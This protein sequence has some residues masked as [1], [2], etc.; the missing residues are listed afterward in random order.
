MN[1]L[2][3]LIENIRMAVSFPETVLPDQ[4]QKYAHDYAEY[5]TELNR[6]I[7]QS[8]QHIRSGNLAE[9]IRLAEMKPNLTEMYQTLD[10]LE[11]EEW[12]DIVSTLG[13]EI[14][15]P[16]S[17]GQLRELNDAYLK[18]SPLEPL[19]RQHRLHALNGSPIRQRLEI[20]RAITKADPE[21]L[22]WNE[23]QEKFEQARIAELNKEIQ[24]AVASGNSDQ[25]RTLYNELSNNNWR[26]LPP[27]EFRQKLCVVML[28][29]DA[30]NLLRYFA[31]FDYTQ[32]SALYEQIQRFLA[33]NKMTLPPDIERTIRPAVLW[34]NETQKRY[35]FENEFMRCSV[36]L[37]QALETES[38]LPTLERLYYALSTAAS[39]AETVIPAELENLY[40]SQISDYEERKARAVKLTVASIVCA[41]LLISGLIAWGLVQRHRSSR[42]QEVLETLQKIETEKRFDD[43]AGTIQRLETDSPYL[44]GQ[45]EIVSIIERLRNLL[46]ED[47]ERAKDFERYY[48]QA[49]ANLDTPEKPDIY[50]LQQIKIDVD[51]AE[52]LAR[53]PQE[54]T[55]FSELKRKF[56]SLLS[57]Q[58]KIL[59]QAYNEKLAEIS[60][61]FNK[62]RKNNSLEI[63]DAFNKFRKNNSLPK[64]EILSQLQNF[65]QQMET[66]QKQNE[67]VSP[68]MKEQ[69]Q[70]VLDSIIL[71]QKKIENEIE[72]NNAF[73]NLIKT[74]P[75]WEDYKTALKNF[76]TKYPDHPAS[77]DAAEVLKEL[78]AVKE[79]IVPLNNLI[80][81]YSK[82][83]DDFNSLQKESEEMRERFELLSSKISGSAEALFSE[84]KILETL[85]KMK[86]F[87]SESF[88]AT[89]P[90]LKN[91]S[92]RQVY[93]W[94]DKEHWYYL[95][96]KPDN[97]GN[98]QYITT[99]VSEEKTFRIRDNEFSRDK[100][101]S[102]TQYQF[103]ITALKKIDAIQD[104]VTEVVC[105]LLEKILSANGIDPILKCVFL[106]SL[107][108]D[109]SEIDPIFAS[110]FKRYHEIVQ[111]SGVDISTNWMDVT[112][113]NTIPQRNLAK[114]ALERL[115]NIKGLTATTLKELSQF[116]N[117][118][119][120]FRP[121]FEW[122]G[123][124][125]RKDGIWNCPTKSTLTGETGDI[126]ILRQKADNTIQPIKIGSVAGGEIQIN[127]TN[128]YLQCSP[129]FFKQ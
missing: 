31:E 42:I 113:K 99:L 1:N 4:I 124:L 65:V 23:D 82:H 25:I 64:N 97:A 15:Q 56:D 77:T 27:R 59:D 74:V 9:G 28:R 19:L 108:S 96:Q 60:D 111:K 100:I 115:P 16:L 49:S 38:P 40:R 118:I 76:I 127:N 121:R 83:A 88:K 21:N 37:Q 120:T 66:L 122:I 89:E 69:G 33:T 12:I 50:K 51:Q 5:C 90:H 128:A 61:A 39:Q 86:P 70:T 54:K 35:A 48:T 24:H 116:K 103:S 45:V 106:D 58:K 14:P 26:V 109:L 71:Y 129:V 62:F 92:Q 17:D 67:N 68:F 32:A 73:Q 98:Y 55:K 123:I 126:Y 63:S 87:T 102:E 7:M 72:Q 10:F 18:M 53:L 13:F 43:I 119:G 30:D 79:V 3:V 85:S 36:A 80:E 46:K 78:D 22:F 84:G 101:F 11:R 112:S 20:L 34:L 2:Q 94:V 105:E 93:P 114:A 41:C 6:R 57:A 104:N 95:T 8:V 125:S 91:L 110:N 44:T 107:I 47:E 75:V 81:V 117:S 29:D 52:Q